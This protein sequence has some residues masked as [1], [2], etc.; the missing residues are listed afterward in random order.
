MRHDPAAAAI[1]IMLRSLMMHGMAQAAAE[2]TEQGA[3]A[4]QSAI[5]ILSQLLKAEIAEREVCSIAY[6][7]KAARFPTYKDLTGFDF[8]SSQLNEALVRKLHA[9]ALRRLP[10]RRAFQHQRD[11]QHPACRIRAAAPRRWLALD[12]EVKDHD[13]I[14]EH[15]TQQL[16]PELVQAHGMGAETAAEMLVLIGDNSNRIHSE[17]DLVKLCG[18]CPVPASSGKTNRHRL[19]RGGNR[20]ANAALY[21][22]II[23]RVRAPHPTLDYVRRRTAEGK[24]KPEIIRCLER[25]VAREIFGYLCQPPCPSQTATVAP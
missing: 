24:T 22:V 21:R 12:T 4:F 2:L 3:P 14:L 7:L 1:A 19:N 8:A 25:Y 15:L 6:Q 5:P 11:R 10:T 18:A 16:A 20:Q 17:A 13:A 9:A 23:V